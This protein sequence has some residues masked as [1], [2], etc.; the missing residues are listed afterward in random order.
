MNH[1]LHQL[2]CFWSDLGRDLFHVAVVEVGHQ[3]WN[4][5]R[6]KGGGK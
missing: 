6:K 2:P 4:A 5:I 1:L 3:V